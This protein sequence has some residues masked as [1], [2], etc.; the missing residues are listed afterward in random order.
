MIGVNEARKIIQTHTSRTRPVI[1]SLLDAS[2]CVLAEDVISNID[3]PPFDQ[4]AMD[5]Y[6]VAFDT[7]KKI[8]DIEVK[9]EIQAGSTG[10]KILYENSAARIF[11]GAPIPEGA[12]TVIMQELTSRNGSYIQISDE[13]IFKGQHIRFKAS[14][15][16]KGE[17][18]AQAGTRITPG[19][20]GYLAGLGISDVAVYPAPRIG[21]IVTGKELVFPGTSL[22]HGQ[23]YESNA[24]TLTSALL[25]GRMEPILTLFSDDNP[26]SLLQ[27]INKAISV[28][29][30]LLITGGI[31][32]GDYD[33]VQ[34][35]LEKIGVEKLLYKIKQKPGKPLYVGK[36]ESSIIFG[37]PGNPAAALTCFYEYVVP[38]IRQMTGLPAMPP[39]VVYMPIG[40]SIDKKPGLT[41]FLKA[42]I[43]N[44][45]VKAM[46]SQESY[47]LSAFTQ[48]DCFIV[49]EEE[50]THIEEGTIVPVHRFYDC[51]T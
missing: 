20:A 39:F 50:Q 26:D 38:C 2:G 47:Q 7:L 10:E 44:N 28:C 18:A 11:T 23:I 8:Q 42:Q 32:A 45:K 17:V 4:S 49:L 29:D 31:S 27:C 48:S 34:P 14:Q 30:I 1:M 46:K 5:G 37:L 40:E 13:K 3:S 22:L 51:W 6:A 12:D 15:I 35:V 41:H 43:Q 33:F 36:H 16:A 25:E 19:V 9:D 21:I 24:V